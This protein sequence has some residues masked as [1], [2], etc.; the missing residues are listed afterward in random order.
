MTKRLV[1]V[2]MMILLAVS[3]A[4][5]RDSQSEAVSGSP[6]E[7]QLPGDIPPVDW[8]NPIGG[9]RVNAV[10]DAQAVMP[11]EVHAPKGLGQPVSILTSDPESTASEDMVIAFLY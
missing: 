5:V 6:T 4:S 9:V 11:F 7:S 3:C 8:D 1:P 2:A 10:A